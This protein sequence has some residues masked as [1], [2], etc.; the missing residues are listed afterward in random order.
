MTRG[1]ERGSRDDKGKER[2]S[3]D[4]KGK[5][6]ETAEMTRGKKERQRR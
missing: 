1:R 5:E 6:R 4:G 2:G 3:G